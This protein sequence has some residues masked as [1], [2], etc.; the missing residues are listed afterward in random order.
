MGAL[1]GYFYAA[2]PRGLYVNLYGSNTLDWNGLHVTETTRY[3]W[4][5]SV[6]FT[7]D[8]KA[9]KEFSLFLRIPDWSRDTRLTVNGAVVATRPGEYAEIHR[10]WKAGDRVALVLDMH[11]RLTQANALVRENNG[12]VAVE[13]GPLVYCLE[14]GDQPLAASLFDE[15]LVVGG[16]ERFN[17]TFRPDVLDGVLILQHA[18]VAAEKPIEDDPLYRDLSLERGG[19]G[20][21]VTLSFIPY[22]AWANR[23]QQEM[24]VWIPLTTGV[25]RAAQ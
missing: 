11:T 1:P 19:E 6:E 5:G 24:E 4:E 10:T 21:P 20:K 23:G 22:Y 3:P 17:E 12:R 13:R 8:P 2:G 9:A 15:S 7:V 16:A 14:K 25:H 18:G